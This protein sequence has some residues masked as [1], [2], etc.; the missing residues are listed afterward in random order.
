MTRTRRSYQRGYLQ[1]H[2]GSWTLRYRER[3]R[4]TGEWRPRRTKLEGF[5]DPTKKKAAQKAAD[6]L[7]AQVNERNNVPIKKQKSKPDDITFRQFAEGRWKAYMISANHQPSTID[8]RN[9]LLKNHLSPFFGEMKMGE[10][11]RSNVSDFFESIQGKVS[12]NTAHNLYGLLGSMFVVAAEHGLCKRSPVRSKIHRPR[13]GKAEKPVLTA[14]QIQAVLFGLP[15]ELERLFSIVIA[16]TGMRMGEALALRRKDFDS[17]AR[18]LSVVHTLYRGRL[19]QPKTETSRRKIKLPPAIAGLI[20]SHL[21]ASTFKDLSDFIF[22]REDGRPGNPIA[23]R[24][25]LYKAMDRAGI[26]RVRGQYG[27]HCLRH[28]A[29]TLVYLTSRDLR[30][31]QELLGHSDISTTSD[32]YVHPG[33]RIV[34]EASEILAREILGNCDPVVTHESD[35]VN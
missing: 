29:G 23:L 32:V 11:S 27:F 17:G 22:C 4:Q 33:D 15:T 12:G 25:H 24:T 18:E 2:R 35:L 20:E 8:Q 1:W 19:K 14:A 10:I 16:V 3:D 28:S 30:M 6:D 34:T 26:K 5:D 31:V 7:I 9:S 13:I 21:A